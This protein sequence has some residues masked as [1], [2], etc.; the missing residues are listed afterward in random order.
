M[1]PNR[2]PF[3]SA[4]RWVVGL[5]IVVVLGSLAFPLWSLTTYSAT[6]EPVESLPAERTYDGGGDVSVTDF[7]DLSARERAVVEAAVEGDGEVTMYGRWRSHQDGDS[8][9][10]FADEW[11]GSYVLGTY[12]TYEGDHYRVA[13]PSG[14]VPFHFPMVAGGGSLAGL[15]VIGL[16]AVGRAANRRGDRRLS[17]VVLAVGFVVGLLALVSLGELGNVEGYLRPIQ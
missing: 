13:Y 4:E 17:A 8:A 11:L 10:P 1:K 9:L 6:V 5:G 7:E 2:N 15:V 16:G 12:V 14:G 3:A